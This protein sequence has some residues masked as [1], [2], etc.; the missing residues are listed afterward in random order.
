MTSTTATFDVG[1]SNGKTLK[2]AFAYTGT[3]RCTPS[4]TF[5][6]LSIRKGVVTVQYGDGS[7]F[8]L[9][10]PHNMMVRRLSTT[11]A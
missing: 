5:K 2:R 9:D 8:Q 7:P 4:A 6:L 1:I 11:R 3:S 10:K